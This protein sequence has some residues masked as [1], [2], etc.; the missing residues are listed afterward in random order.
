MNTATKEKE[1]T[2]IQR[3]M[4]ALDDVRE[5][6]PG[7]LTN[8]ALKFDAEREWVLQSCEKSTYATDLAAGNVDATGSA[9]R[10]VAAIG[11]TL[12]PARKLAYV[13][14]RD[15]KMVYDLSYRGLIDIA[16]RAKAILWAQAAIVHENDTFE[17]Q[18]YDAPPVHKYNPFSKAR[19]EIVGAYVVVK[20]PSGDYLTNS[21]PVDEINGIRDRSSAWK[22]RDAKKPG[23][24][25]PWET[26][27]SE[28]AKKTVV[29]NGWK[30]WPSGEAPEL[31]ARAVHYLNTDGGQGIDL[32]PADESR[33]LKQIWLAKVE[34]AENVDDLRA[35]L[36]EARKA[37]E[38]VQD[39]DGY[40]EVRK[41]AIARDAKLTG[42]AKP[43][44]TAA[45][46]AAK[47]PAADETR[48]V[49]AEEREVASLTKAIEAATTNEELEATG[50]RIDALGESEAVDAL[51]KL[52]NKVH[53]R[54][55]PKE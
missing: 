40:G 21:M 3:V 12:D 46:A 49:T 52:Y 4:R 54:I 29:K 9:L 16:I 33:T 22:G 35:L 50:P 34:E 10:N 55:N 51:N 45:P 32:T 19:G 7:L 14:P 17:L 6:W 24:G 41:A 23:S 15:K 42:K 2:P 13:L 27:W 25:G 36:P 37:F 38:A 28:M 31:L 47:P 5:D 1:P 43:A 8:P 44:A 11:V 48:A 39:P 18:G 30:Y 20:T 53:A 26:D